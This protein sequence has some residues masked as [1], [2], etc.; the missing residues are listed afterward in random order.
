MT[1][2]QQ[3]LMY[4]HI[5]LEQAKHNSNDYPVFIANLDAFVTDARS[6]TMNMQTEF[7]SIKGFKEWY[8]V[9]QQEMKENSDFDFFNSL[10]RVTTHVHPFNAASKI[11]TSFQDGMTISGGKIVDIP[12]GKMGDRDF[13]IDNTTP[14]SI[15]GKSAININRS[16]TRNYFFTDKPNE[17]AIARCEAYIQKLKELVARC[18]DQF[19][20]L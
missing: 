14:V 5:M 10:R 16:T 7:D 1:D 17:D 12:L 13:I 18:H 19:N 20:L 4:A 2:T 11:T 6:V 8:S 15:N 9:K 3:K